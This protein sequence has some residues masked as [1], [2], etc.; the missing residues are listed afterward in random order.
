MAA[1]RIFEKTKEKGVRIIY[2]TNFHEHP[3]R[4]FARR[5]TSTPH[6]VRTGRGGALMNAPW[7]FVS[8]LMNLVR[9]NH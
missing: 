7:S 2:A 6:S 1:V 4:H 8:S 9:E 5:P 3:V